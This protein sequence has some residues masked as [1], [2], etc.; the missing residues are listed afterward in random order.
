[1]TVERPESA[2]FVARK[3]LAFFVHPE[4]TREEV[5]ALAECYTGRDRHVGRTLRVLLRS[6]LFFSERAWGGRI[7]DPIDRQILHL[8][9]L[10]NRHLVIAE[11]VELAPTAVRKR[12][13]EIRFK[14]HD[15]LAAYRER[16]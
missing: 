9:L 7:K 8:W 11:Y 15:R 10:G 3:L 2:R 12:W 4:P 6:R 16:G 14:L 13:Q 1:M 5:E